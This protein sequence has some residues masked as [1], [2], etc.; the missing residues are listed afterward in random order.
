MQNR[1]LVF[2]SD[3]YYPIGGWDDFYRAFDNLEDAIKAM[4]EECDKFQHAHV[5]DLEKLEIIKKHNY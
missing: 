2:I 5:V 3:N 4:N 1:Y